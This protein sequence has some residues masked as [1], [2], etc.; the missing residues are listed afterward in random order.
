MRKMNYIKLKYVMLLGIILLLENSVSYGQFK[1][2]LQNNRYRLAQTYERTGEFTKAEEIYSELYKSNPLNI[3]YFNSLNN[4]YLKQKKYL[5][6]VKLI[7]NRLIRNPNDISLYAL[8]G[9]T[10]YV[11]GNADKAFETWDKALQILPNSAV[12]YR[13]IA[14]AMIENRE[15]DRAIEVLEKAKKSVENPIMFSYDLAQLYSVKTDYEN[16]TKE[17]CYIISKRPS[18]LASIKRRIA[19]YFINNQARNATLKVVNEFY[20]STHQPEFL[21][22]LKYLYTLKGDYETAYKLAV[23]LDETTTKNGAEIFVFAQNALR[24]NKTNIASTAFKYIIDNY[25]NSSFFPS[26]KIGYAGSLEQAI[27]KEDKTE[28]TDWK[29]FKKLFTKKAE[30]YATVIKAYQGIAKLFPGTNQY[31]EALYRM[32]MIYFRK[33]NKLNKADSLFRKI[34]NNSPFSK[35]GIQSN[36]QL[37]EISIFKND[38]E[39]AK[40]YL[41][42]VLKNKRA[43]SEE[44]SMAKYKLAKIEFWQGNFGSA[45]KKLDKIIDNLKDKNANDAIE[46]KLLI[47]TL[48]SD[49]LS[50]VKFAE[51]DLLIEKGKYSQAAE[52]YKQLSGNENIM[53]FK[54]YALLKR[55]QSLI[56]IDYYPVVVSELTKAI[57]NDKFNLYSDKFL[58]LLGNTYFYG[59]GENN[60]ALKTFQ[61]LLEKF[62]N[63]LYFDKAR[64]TI[65]LITNN[66]SKIL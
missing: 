2:K 56:A 1:N 64:E 57:E 14:N 55:E 5:E 58:F 30:K 17:F 62:P 3:N 54:D 28:N 47:T 19:R 46:L 4:I 39:K 32:G 8:L 11:S 40:K 50:L 13:L 15:F 22:L 18:E 51:G 48:K 45:S 24:E 61:K 35:Y 29:P 23:E 12:S 66:K 63:S 36:I 65:N 21:R 7:K 6:S 9:T 41:D 44:R 33:L 34:I 20:G 53:F 38:F 16:A 31:Y 60:K 26:A 27:N 10:Y 43:N 42:N 59:L 37:G 52:I 49:S 25:P